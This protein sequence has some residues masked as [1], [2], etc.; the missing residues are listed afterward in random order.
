MN[1]TRTLSDWAAV[2]RVAR[3]GGV[4]LDTAG[5][6]ALAAH[7]VEVT[8]AAQSI[9]S[10]DAETYLLGEC[11][12]DEIDSD[13]AENTRADLIDYGYAEAS[14]E[15]LDTDTIL[16]IASKAARADVDYWTALECAVDKIAPKL[17]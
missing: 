10:G 4:E 8:D 9:N 17:P 12:I 5:L 13:L 14:V 3:A 15:A 16:S 7:L 6:D 2:V 11:G 1:K